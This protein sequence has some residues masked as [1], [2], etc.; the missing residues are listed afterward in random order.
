M[1]TLS[2]LIQYELDGLRLGKS[3]YDSD[4]NPE[5][6]KKCPYNTNTYRPMVAKINPLEQNGFEPQ[7]D[8]RVSY[9]LHL[10]QPKPL[11]RIDPKKVHLL[12]TKTKKAH[13]LQ[14]HSLATSQW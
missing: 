14:I 12:T 8:T 6:W 2:D 4:K 10:S 9:N 5:I 11:I 3:T 13:T 1:A 7:I